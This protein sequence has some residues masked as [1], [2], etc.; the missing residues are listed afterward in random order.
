MGHNHVVTLPFN[1]GPL[2]VRVAVLMAVCTVTAFGMVRAFLPQHGRK[3]AALVAGAAFAAILLELMLAARVDLPSQVV[4][5]LLFATAMP[6]WLIL[7]RDNV[8]LARVRDSAPW[9][10]SVTA[11]AALGV[12]GYASFT[13]SVSIVQTGVLPALAGLSWFAACRAPHLVTR[14]LVGLLAVAALGATAHVTV[15]RMEPAGGQENVS[16]DRQERG[17]FDV[18][19]PEQGRFQPGEAGTRRDVGL[20]QFEQ[21][22]AVKVEDGCDVGDECLPRRRVADLVKTVL[23]HH[24]AD[25][26]PRGRPR[27]AVHAGR[28][29]IGVPAGPATTACPAVGTGENALHLGER[30]SAE[31]GERLDQPQPPDMT[32][33]V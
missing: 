22:T 30:Q 33:V 31:V 27:L 10:T 23:G 16:H 9:V 18:V 29:G 20:Q 24:P 25:V 12:F 13:S 28:S 8:T 7:S 19:V 14:V 1:I 2:L 11:V 3:E 15:S 21:I 32:V 26:V 4:V 17:S 5:L 6:V